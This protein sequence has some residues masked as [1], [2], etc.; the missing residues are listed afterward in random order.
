MEIVEAT[1]G[2]GID[3]FVKQPLAVYSGDHFYPTPIFREMRKHLTADNPFFD[4]AEVR[5]FLAREG[6]RN[7]G[8]IASIVNRN[9]IDFHGEKAG[10]FGFFESVRD[11]AV[12]G[13]L[14]D[15]AAEALRGSGMQRMRGPMS[16]S[17]NDEC[18]LLVEGFDEPPLLMTPY[19]PPYYAGL[20]EACGMEKAKDLYAYIYRIGETLPEKIHKVAAVAEGKGIRARPLRVSHFH[21]D[22]RVFQEIYNS[23]WSENWGFVPITDRE[24]DYMAEKLRDAI[25]PELTLI[26]EAPGGEPVGFMGLVPDYNLVLRHLHGRLNA[27]TAMK[28]L[29]YSRRITDL[30]L[31]LLGIKKEYRL[32]GVD[33]LLFREGFKGVKK[34]HYR[35]VEFSWIL[36]DNVRVRRL[37]EMSGARHYKTFR[38]YERELV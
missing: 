25:V 37:V 33:A 2:A 17:T 5:F 35:R 38:I 34:G 18:G 14:L 36:E 23:A 27:L 11:P 31:L 22:M 30:R 10:F 16:F 21:S 26:A 32:R 19:N 9:H 8:R 7:V 1:A 3:A 6:G 28:A 13:A 24:L 20:M 15:R 29:Y 12:A 4:H